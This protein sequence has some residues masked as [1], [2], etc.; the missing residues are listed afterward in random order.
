MRM[1]AAEDRVE[2]RERIVERVHE[3]AAHQIDHQNA[4]AFVEHVEAPAGARGSLREIGRPQYPPIAWDVGDQL[5]L[6]PDVIAGG[7]DVGPGVVKLAGEALGQAERRRRVLGID[8]REIDPE[9]APQPGKM[10]L[11]RVA[12]GASD[13][14]AAEEDVQD[15]SYPK[16]AGGLIRWVEPPRPSTVANPPWPAIAGGSHVPE[17]RLRQGQ[18]P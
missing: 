5:A 8:D 15:Y 17:P 3:Q 11:D 14:I 18:P 16:R 7:Q 4:A 6:V 1:M 12:P 13:H 9:V 2:P 10:R